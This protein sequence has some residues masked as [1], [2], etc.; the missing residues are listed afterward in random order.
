MN[1]L[2]DEFAAK[3]P[4]KIPGIHA[5]VLP[6]GRWLLYHA[7]KSAAITLNAPAGILWELCDGQT[8]IAG[9]I[10][11]LVDLYPNTL[12]DTLADETRQM[13]HMLV[14]QNLIQMP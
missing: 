3:R 11:Q 7:E 6:D 10:Q 9:I 12:V 8:T 4:S 14:D 2:H 13:I 1:P 5:T